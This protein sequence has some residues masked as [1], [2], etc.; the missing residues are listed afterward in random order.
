[1]DRRFAVSRA[2][3]QSL[4]DTAQPFLFTSAS[5]SRQRAGRA[6]ASELL[7]P[8]GG[9][10]TMLSS[11]NALDPEDVVSDIADH[12]RAGDLVVLQQ[13]ENQLS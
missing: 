8:A 7:A 4:T 11:F 9:I 3:W 2:L 10:R 1:V 12:F 6:F 13:I 5:S